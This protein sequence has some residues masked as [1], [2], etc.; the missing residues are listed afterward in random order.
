MTTSPTG[1]GTTRGAREH[2][3]AQEGTVV[4]HAPVVPAS[5]AGGADPGTVWSER[6]AGGGYAHRA[7]A[8]GTTIRL[9]D[10]VGDACA[11]V[12][13][14]VAGSPWERLNVADTVKVQWQVYAGVGQ[15][16]LSDQGRVLA[17]IIEDTSGHHDAIFGTSTQTRNE[18]RYGDGS[19]QGGSPAGRELFALGGAKHGLGRRDLPPCVSFFKGIRVDEGGCPVWEGGGPRPGTSIVLRAEMPLI[20]LIANAAHPLDPRPTYEVTPLDVTATRG[21]PTAADDEL[22]SASPEGRR[23]FENTHDHLA[24]QG[25][26]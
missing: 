16:L 18:E 22:W 12:L 11:S 21:L 19:P 20:V 4:E 5:S 6:I 26:A 7:L 14:F 13:L 25:L 9:T 23:A 2:A 3:R 17:S 1:T 24:G 15:L 10:V 8:R